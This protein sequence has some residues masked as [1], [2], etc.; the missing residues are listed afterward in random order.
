MSR[1][2]ELGVVDAARR[3][4]GCLRR[5]V[6]H[7]DEPR[8]ALAERSGPELREQRAGGAG[9]IWSSD[10]STRDPASAG[11]ST[12]TPMAETLEPTSATR[13]R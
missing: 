5:R 13:R 9:V 11:E 1:R 2:A 4:F 6:E 8:D 3:Q 7:L 10:V 12:G